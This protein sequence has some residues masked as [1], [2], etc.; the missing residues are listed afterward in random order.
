MK[1]MRLAFPLMF[2]TGLGQILTLLVTPFLT[3]NYTPSD[4]G[5][6][7]LFVLISSMIIVGSAFRYDMSILLPS[8][9]KD[10]L[11]LSVVSI[12]HV[13]VTTSVSA[14]FLILFALIEDDSFN[15]MYIALPLAIFIGGINLVLSA[16]LNYLKKYKNMATANVIQMLATLILNVIFCVIDFLT[17]SGGELIIAT[18]I[19]QFTYML[20]QLFFLK[21]S[22]REMKFIFRQ[23]YSF[24]LAKRYHNFAIYSLPACYILSVTTALPIYSLKI[25]FTSDLLGQYVLAN[26]VLLVPLAVIGAAMS[27][28]LIRHFSEKVNAGG[29][30]LDD[31]F[32]IW[33]LSLMIFCV[34]AVAL[35][36]YAEVIMQVIFGPNWVVA[37]QL[38]S[39]LIIPIMFNFCINMVSSAHVVLGMQALSLYFSLATLAFKL[40]VTYMFLDSYLELLL[41]YIF[42]ETLA[43][44]SMNLLVIQRL[45]KRA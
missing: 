33:G 10:V 40:A 38:V 7:G 6:W 28:V 36:L 44:V 13:L 23:R 25:L 32:K 43:I 17:V 12:K 1:L 30:I 45:W 19:G 18:V 42:I 9:R 21:V 20:V 8:S 31:I 4:F 16:N 22:I 15:W 24:R 34:P 3:R 37:G 14:V 39:L 5:D 2:G 35:F 11:R 26:R 29:N 27:Q 41:S